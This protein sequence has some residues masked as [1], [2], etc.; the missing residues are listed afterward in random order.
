MMFLQSFW[1]D[2]H[3]PSYRILVVL[4]QQ[5]LMYGIIIT[6][7]FLL[8]VKG[9]AWNAPY[10]LEVNYCNNFFVLFM[11]IAHAT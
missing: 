8:F 1:L 4:L 3:S 2:G 6:Y 10:G 5:K 7:T 11:G 9:G